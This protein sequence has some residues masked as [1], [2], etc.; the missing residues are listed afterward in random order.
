MLTRRAALKGG[1]AVACVAAA[2]MVAVPVLAAQRN[3]DTRV[4]ALIE[5]HGGAARRIRVA[6]SRFREVFREALPP[7]LRDIGFL[8]M[9][10]QD[11]DLWYEV[12]RRPSLQPFFAESR[13]LND[14]CKAVVERLGETPASTLEGIHAKFQDATKVGRR[15]RCLDDEIALSAVDDLARLLGEG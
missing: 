9:S 1:S 2:G 15:G 13:R 3:P 11:R 5:E 6:K 10:G 12:V 4:F 14:E 8:D 7:H